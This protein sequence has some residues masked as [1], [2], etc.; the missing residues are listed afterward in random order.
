M[1]EGRATAPDGV[2]LVYDVRGKGSTTLVFVHCWACDRTYWKNQLDEFAKTFRVVSLDLGGHGQSGD[3]RAQ[4][5][6]ASL[7]GDVQAVVE[8]LDLKNVI[9]VGHSMG[10][11]VSL[12]AARRMP[13]RVR[14]IACVETL[15]DVEAK[16]PPALRDQ[17]IALFDRADA[18]QAADRIRRLGDEY[19]TAGNR[20]L[21]VQ[22]RRAAIARET[23]RTTICNDRVEIVYALIETP[24]KADAELAIEEMRGALEHGDAQCVTEAENAVWSVAMAWRKLKV[25][26]ARLLRAWDRAAE[27]SVRPERR[28]AALRIRGELTGP[29]STTR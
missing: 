8:K 17:A 26:R 9:L 14:G 1:V 20:S 19:N 24:N 6:I 23:D 25:G 13:G 15:H 16:L 7:G 10:G 12:D 21:E 22:A 5:T 11:P 29:K 28:A 3:N 4:W 18:G 2:E 27:L